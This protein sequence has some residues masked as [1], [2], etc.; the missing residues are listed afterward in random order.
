[1]T[2]GRRTSRFTRRTLPAASATRTEDGDEG[3]ATAATILDLRTTG[4][5]NLLAALASRRS[6]CRMAALFYNVIGCPK[7]KYVLQR[8]TYSDS[9][10]F[11]GSEDAAMVSAG[12]GQSNVGKERSDEPK[13][14]PGV[15]NKGNMSLQY[16]IIS[17][18]PFD[19]TESSRQQ[20]FQNSPSSPI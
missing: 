11:R 19:E 13:K 6:L 12:E 5:P 1:M 18:I 15:E 7:V 4:L 16:S 14:W 20:H 2:T 8:T 10:K 17:Y 3:S 9:K